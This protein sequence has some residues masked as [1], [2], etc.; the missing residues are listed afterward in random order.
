MNFE[1]YYHKP[2]AIKVLAKSLVPPRI[3]MRTA[4]SL[5]KIKKEE[6]KTME[7]K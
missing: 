7:N 1:Y 6:I 4:S 5:W 2:L 3:S